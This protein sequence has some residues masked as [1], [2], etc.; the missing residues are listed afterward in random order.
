VKLIAATSADLRSSVAAGRFRPD[1]YQRLAVVVVT[2][3]PLRERDEDLLLLAEHYLRRAAEAHGV[4]PKRLSRAA[5]AWLGR[6]PWPGNV[7]ELSHLLERVTLLSPEAIVSPDTLE[8]LGLP[9]PP[10]PKPAEPAAEGETSEESEERTQLLA[11]LRQTRGNVVQAARLLGLSR[12][13]LRHRLRRYGL[14]RPQAHAPA[15]APSGTPPRGQRP[16]PPEA[17]RA[18]GPPTALP[19]MWEHKPVAVL[20]I[21]LTFPT[22][23]A[24]ESVA[25]EPWTAARRWEHM[26][27][28]KVQG[29]GGVVLQRSPAL[30][31][32]AFGIPQTL[33]QQPQRAV[34]AALAL[35][36]LVAEGADQASC[37]ALR[38]VVHWGEGLVDGQAR[39]PTAQ[40]RVLGETCAWPVRL[41]GHVAPGEIVLSPPMGRLVE[42]WCEMQ[43][44]AVSLPGEP[45]PRI[46]VSVVVASRPP[47]ARWARQGRRPLSPFVGREEELA[48]VH[49]RLRQAE[50]GHGQVVAVL[51]EPGVG[52]SRLC[53][54]VAQGLMTPPWRLLSMQ[55]TAAGQA[56]PYRPLLDLLQGYFHL[57][58]HADQATIRAQVTAT[59]LAL[60]VALTPTVPAFLT[61]LDVPVEDPLWQ[62]LEP[63]RRRQRTLAALKQLFVREAQVQP[64]LLLVEDLQWL[65]TETQAVLD[66]LVD[67][68]PPARLLLLVTYRP[69]YSHG[70]GSKAAYTQLRLDPLP[71]VSA[72]ALLRTLLGDDPSL[73]PLQQLLIARTAGNPFFLEE[74]VRT[75]VETGGLVGAPGA[76]RL[77]QALPTLPVPATVQAVLAARLDRLPP[78]AKRLLQI[79][80]VIGPEV[81]VPLLQAIT[82]LPED[83]LPRSL[84]QL[85]AAAFLYETRLFPEAAY[86]FTHAL[87][88]EVAYETLVQDRRRALHARLVVALE[89]LAADRIAEPVD[90]L[91]YHALRGEVWDKA[92]S[93][94][95]QAGVRARARAAFHEAVAAFE[96]ALQALAHLPDDGDARRLAIDL[97]LAVGNS[98]YVLGEY[99]RWR[100]RL[101]EAE[102]LARGLDDRAR[103]GW[104]LDG[105]AR[106]IRRTGDSDGAIAVG[107]QTLDLAVALGDRTLQRQASY[108][109]G[110]EYYMI[111]DF[112]RA[113]ELLRRSMEAADGEPGTPSTASIISC[114]A[115]LARTLSALGAFPEARRHGQEAL[116]LATVDGR[117]NAP[118]VAHNCLGLL[119]LTQGDLVPAIRVLEQG[120]ALCRASGN[121]NDL[122]SVAAHLGSAYALQGRL[123]DGRVL[124]EEGI[125]ETT[126]TGRLQYLSRL[127]TWLSEV[128]RLAGA[129]EEA[130]GYAHQALDL[131]RRHKERANEAYALHQLGTVQAQADTPNT[132]QAETHYRQ[133][134]ALAE[135]LGMRPLVAHC[136]LGLGRLYGQTGRGE[137]ARVALT[138][139]IDLYRAMDMTFWLPQAEA[140]LAEV[141]GH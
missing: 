50:G 102:A 58:G 99:G 53:D 140:A 81:P 104:V 141:E 108:T 65:D 94:C 133:A 100:A 67:S 20:A 116:R 123:A 91:A 13:A 4:R 75:L 63:A 51:G 52:K 118:I 71:L 114:L 124:L 84:A 109:L 38:L 31:L 112:G 127:L 45:S 19:P 111:G 88:H 7:R 37:P 137:E 43:P 93:Y 131:A 96:Q 83:A 35:R 62:G 139:A 1:L 2:L 32:V 135:A 73:A 80:A 90:R 61:L 101:G 103:L 128:C 105:M 92:V 46:A 14:Q 3:P 44:R 122:R 113:A 60:D 68:L 6:Y 138:T 95:Q 74:S 36:Q 117:G 120:L 21:E 26:L 28:E 77:A 129:R 87:T 64:V 107:Q 42:A 57:D 47:G 12:G 15:L 10:A 121:R 97:R 25:Y 110:Q 22:I 72:E 9:P 41:L 5:E 8:A 132:D 130:W 17:E 56:T 11:A 119:Y 16:M 54:E 24:G 30:L 39:D 76:Y 89:A 23:T 106:V 48:T 70:W 98:L 18:V 69:E 33:E 136:H 27:I 29:F 40:L 125:H 78:E 85:Q 49:T 126:H 66:T 134:L 55:G 86:T 115:W 82:D 59:L 79:A 34:Q